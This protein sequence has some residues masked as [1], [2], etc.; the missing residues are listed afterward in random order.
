MPIRTV[1]GH[2]TSFGRKYGRW[3]LLAL[4]AVA[5]VLLVRE[6]G[7]ERVLNVLL[8]SAPWL[9]LILILEVA[10]ISMD[11]VAL[12]FL[13]REQAQRVPLRAWL[14]S[15]A[16]AY[17]VMILLP[18]GRAGGEVLRAAQLSRYVGLLSA[19]AAA[20]LQ[21]ST[22]FANAV[23]SVPCFIAV[24]YGVGVSHGLALLIALNG[25]ATAVLGLGVLFITSRSELGGKLGRRF[26]F[27]QQYA[28]AL[29]EAAKPLKAFPR[30]AVLC[31]VVGRVIQALQY[32]VILLAIGGQLTVSSALVAQGIHLV[33]SGLGDMIPNAVGITETAYRVFAPTLG[34]ADEPARAIAIALVA[35]LTQYTLAALALLSGMRRSSE[36]EV[37]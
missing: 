3:L 32:G 7:P 20:Q 15:A 24:A 19:T 25:L 26:S 17:G 36:E 22:L 4:G 29:D 30:R 33:G 28:T 21:G 1:F 5:V 18:A 11:V 37:A 34:F 23:I 9:P 12:R 8:R 2:L 14:K 6:S 31:T 16:V 13:Y 10:W 27:M 35:R